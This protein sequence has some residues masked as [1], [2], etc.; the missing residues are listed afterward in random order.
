MG[1]GRKT[2]YKPRLDLTASDNLSSYRLY[3][4]LPLRL[5]HD[6]TDY[7][8]YGGTLVLPLELWAVDKN[9]PLLLQGK[10]QFRLCDFSGCNPRSLELKLDLAP[11]TSEAS[12]VNNFIINNFNLL[13]PAEDDNLTVKRLVVDKPLSADEPQV[14]RVVIDIDTALSEFDIFIENK[15]GIEFYAPRITIDGRRII[16]RFTAVDNRADLVGKEFVL[17]AKIG[18]FVS[19]RQ[20][21]TAEIASVFDTLRPEL[22][23]GLVFLAF[24]GGF[25]LNFMPCVFPAL[26][27]KLMSL[28][29]FGGSNEQTVRRG[30]AFDGRWHIYRFCDQLCS[31]FCRDLSQRHPVHAGRTV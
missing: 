18:K 2:H 7:T 6:K 8:V 14:L 9:K 28:S 20:K 23:W 24:I 17:T 30:F 13:P 22:S 10:L 19:L 31:L 12:A 3:W 16:A 15:D 25:I 4:P 5:Y 21:F 29:S 27:L 26:S 1:C 11:G